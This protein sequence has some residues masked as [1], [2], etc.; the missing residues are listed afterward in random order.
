MGKGLMPNR[1]GDI[2]KTMLNAHSNSILEDDVKKETI[3]PINSDKTINKIIVF[4][5]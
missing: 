3:E 2:R 4:L 1:E 5:F